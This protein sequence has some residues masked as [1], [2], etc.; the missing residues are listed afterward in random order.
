MSHILVQTSAAFIETD[1]FTIS[2]PMLHITENK[3]DNKLRRSSEKI[4]LACCLSRSVNELV[5]E[6]SGVL[7]FTTL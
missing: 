6:L 1:I 2:Q 7:L 3:T 4:I 5:N